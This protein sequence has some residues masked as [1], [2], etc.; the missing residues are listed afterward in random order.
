MLT[1]RRIWNDL[2]K[3]ENVDLYLTIAAAVAF[4]VLN[5]V[6]VA[7][8]TLLAPLTLAVLALLA[9]TSLGN[10]H[11]MD[12]LLQQ[13]E[14]SL[15]DFFREEFPPSYKSDLETAEELWLV[16]VS[17]HRTVTSNYPLLERKL[18]RGHRLRVLLVHPDGA[19][20]EMAVARGYTR[21]DL[22]KKRQEILYVLDLLCDLRQAAPGRVEVRTIQHPL[23]YGAL[24]ANPDTGAGVLYLEHY[25]FR[26]TTE[27]MPRYLLRVQDGRWYD[28]FKTELKALWAAGADWSCQE[29][30]P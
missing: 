8:T 20:L 3:G 1:L 2:R 21:R 18:Q 9:I 23:A 5:L 7:P 15:D 19:G 16:G 11:R 27:S 30:T 17:L 26:V 29:G 14:R 4:V 6:G 10:R 22:E 24:A 28:F 13:R 12:E 25:C